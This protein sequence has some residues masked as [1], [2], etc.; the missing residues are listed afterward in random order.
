MLEKIK[1]FIFDMD[2]VFYKGSKKLQG[3]SEIIKYLQKQ[4]IPFIFLTNNSR[5]SIDDYLIKLAKLNIYV[6]KNQI[7]TSAILA[8]EYIKI[9]YYNQNLKIYGSNSLKKL[10]PQNIINKGSSE[11]ILIGMND[12]LTLKDISEIRTFA[13][14]GKQL[15]FT[16][17]DEL[18]P[19]ENGYDLE[20][21]SIIQLVKNHCKKEVIIVGKPSLFAFD[22]S[23]K[24]LNIEKQYIAMVGDT[25]STDIKGAIDI[26]ILAIHLQTSDDSY[27]KNKLEALEFKNLDSLLKELKSF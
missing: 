8:R 25:Y 5:K 3:A 1:A 14:E 10:F 16:N 6:N 24:K 4:N 22:Y 17:P 23:I 2:G 9:H 11:I 13:T 15:I 27:N 7:I 19:T 26:D 18:I 20:C 21:G 12:L